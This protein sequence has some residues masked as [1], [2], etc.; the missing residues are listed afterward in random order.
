MMIKNKDELTIFVAV[1]ALNEEFIKL[2][3][4]T[5]LDKAAFPNRIS[6]GIWEQT[7]NNSFTNLPFDK[8]KKIKHIKASYGAMLGVG[9]ARLNALSLYANEDFILSIDAHSIFNVD[10]DINLINNYYKISNYLGH[11]NV[12]IS[13]QGPWWRFNDDGSIFYS[14]TKDKLIAIGYNAPLIPEEVDDVTFETYYHHPS[15]VF[16]CQAYKKEDNNTYVALLRRGNNPYTKTFTNFQDMTAWLATGNYDGGGYP[17]HIGYDVNSQELDYIEQFNLTASCMFSKAHFF[18]DIMPDPYYMFGGEEPAWAMRASTRGYQIFSINKTI[19]WHLNKM[20]TLNPND[21][22][23]DPGIPE[24]VLDAQTKAKYGHK[25]A[26]RFL[27]GDE[28]G[29]WG[30]PSLELL[31]EYEQQAGI[32]FNKFYD[33]IEEYFWQK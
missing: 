26:E 32:D 24:L 7:T 28:L 3:V 10:W 20:G 30:A 4:D 17:R 14:S 31:K 1:A 25:R 9:I 15:L 29:Y 21:R 23:L 18:Q 33:E 12:V 16:H 2:T 27:R 11:D 5:A 6:F 13:V 22:L 8:Y 19:L